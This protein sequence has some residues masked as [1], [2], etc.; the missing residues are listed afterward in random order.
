MGDLSYDKFERDYKTQDAVIRNFEIIGKA[1]KN[2]PNNIKEANPA[3]P[4]REMA[5]MRDKLSHAYFGI[6]ISVVW[7][8]ITTRL[9]DIKILLQEL[10]GISSS[11]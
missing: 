2:I 5:G 1:A 7:K 9:P 3:V 6:K 11:S 10:K 8:T 4:W